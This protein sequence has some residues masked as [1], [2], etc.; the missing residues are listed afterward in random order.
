LNQSDKE[1]VRDALAGNVAAFAALYERYYGLAVGLARCS[2]RDVHLAE[3]AAQETFAVACKN[4]S[5]LREPNKFA[6]WL[7]TICRH[8]ASQLAQSRL[9]LEANVEQHQTT[10]NLPSSDDRID[11]D[12]ALMQLDE[13]SREVIVLHYFS[14][15]SHSEIAAA[16]GLSSA[17]VHG[18]LQR[19]RR[20]LADYL[21]SFRSPS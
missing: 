16:L 5:K 15:L 7:G 1:L 10:E 14:A 21:S 12:G 13:L 9:N 17:A 20:K 4:L 11:I 6:Q 2:L 8:T 18:R 19:A 3:D